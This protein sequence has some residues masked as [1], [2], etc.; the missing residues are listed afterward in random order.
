MFSVGANRVAPVGSADHAFDGC[1]D[2][3][4]NATTVV[5]SAKSVSDHNGSNSFVALKLQISLWVLCLYHRMLELVVR[6]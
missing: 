1:S 6:V 4:I 3:S 2:D 5:Y